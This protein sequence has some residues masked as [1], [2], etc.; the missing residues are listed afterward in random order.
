MLLFPRYLATYLEHAL[1]FV[2]AYLS[3]ALT[4]ILIVPFLHILI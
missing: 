3:P 2:K 4:F 1:R